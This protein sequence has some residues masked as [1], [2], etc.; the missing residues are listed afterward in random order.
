LIEIVP[1]LVEIWDQDEEDKG[2]QLFIDFE[3]EKAKIEKYD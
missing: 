3:Q 2:F 1:K